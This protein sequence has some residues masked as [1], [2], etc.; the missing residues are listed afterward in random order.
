Y[1][2]W[3]LPVIPAAWRPALEFF[4]VLLAQSSFIRQTLDTTL[5]RTMSVAA[6]HPLYL[7]ADIRANRAR[8]DLG[9]DDLVYVASFEFASDP[10]R[11]TVLGAVEAFE[12]GL[13]DVPQA[14]LIIKVNNAEKISARNRVMRA[15]QDASARDPRIRIFAETLDY[16]HVLSLY[17]SSD[18]FVSLHRSEGLGLGPME[19]MALGK[20]VV[21]TAW[22]GTMEYMDHTTACLVPY[23]L[24]PTQGARGVYSPAVVGDAARWAEPD[25]EEAARWMKRLANEASLRQ[26]IGDRA[27][28]AIAKFHARAAQSTFACELQA[29]WEHRLRAG[30]MPTMQTML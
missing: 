19:A 9:V 5:S 18:V 15:L 7:P 6:N 12:R 10:A 28:L 16:E 22:S 11:K 13:A 1:T 17:A 25:I 4:D 30:R 29:I 27:R 24:V 20:A 23:R 2:V 21:A 8:F 26:A 14:R 3:E